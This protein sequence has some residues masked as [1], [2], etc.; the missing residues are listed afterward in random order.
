MFAPQNIS[1]QANNSER[2]PAW[3]VHRAAVH[4]WR[5]RGQ[6]DAQKQVVEMCPG[7][8]PPCAGCLG[9]GGPEISHSM[10]WCLLSIHYQHLINYGMAGDL[11]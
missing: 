11:Q 6:G 8:P 4:H 5:T 2:T 3:E 7:Q 10:K 1:I 9:A